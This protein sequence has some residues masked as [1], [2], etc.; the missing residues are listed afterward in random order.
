VMLYDF[1]PADRLQTDLLGHVDI[2]AHTRAHDRMDAIDQLNERYGKNTIRYAAEDLAGA[3]KPKY[4]LR[5]PRYTTNMDELPT[6]K[7]RL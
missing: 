2:P 1:V 3:W 4:H 5:S 7:P 6:V